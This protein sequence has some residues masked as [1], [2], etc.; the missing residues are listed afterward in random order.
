MIHACSICGKTV[1]GLEEYGDSNFPL[2][3]DHYAGLNSQY[4]D[5]YYGLAPHEHTYAVDGTILLGGTN[6]LDVPM[7]ENFTPDPDAPGLG[8]WQSN[9]TPGWM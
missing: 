2:C 4:S 9:P 8:V 7:P 6:F 1:K 3:W 5:S